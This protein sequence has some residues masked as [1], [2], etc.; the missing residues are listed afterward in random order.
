MVDLNGCGRSRRALF[1]AGLFLSGLLITSLGFSSTAAAQVQEESWLTWQQSRP[2]R[3][4]PHIR[5][6]RPHPEGAQ[7]TAQCASPE[8]T[9]FGGPVISN[10]QIVLVY[11]NSKV[12]TTAQA[13]LPTFFEGVTDSTF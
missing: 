13:D 7:V 11:W 12:S 9:Y 1:T 3:S 8:V 2:K 10:A 6:K 4:R 5:I